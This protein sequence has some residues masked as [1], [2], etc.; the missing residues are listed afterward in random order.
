MKHMTIV[1]LALVVLAG[2]AAA[3]TV[4]VDPDPP[5]AG[6]AVTV[7]YDPTGRPLEGA[8]AVYLHYGYNGWH[9]T[10]D[11]DASM[12]WNAGTSVWEVTVTVPSQAVE[13][14]MAFNDGAGTWD[15]NDG[16]NWTIA[17]T[18]GEP[19]P[20]SVSTSPDPVEASMDVTISY[21]AT[22]GPLASASAV[23]LHHG[24]NNWEIV[25]SDV[26]MTWE[27]DH[28]EATVS[29][30][31]Y[32]VEFDCSFFDDSAEPIWDNNDGFDWRLAVSGGVPRVSV[33][34]DPPVAGM[35]VTITYNPD[36]TVLEGATQVFLH[37]GINDFNPT[38]EDVA[39]N[40]NGPVWEV[41]VTIPIRGCELNFVFN[42]GA[43]TWDNNNG[44]DWNIATEGC[45]PLE[46][47]VDNLY[48]AKLIDPFDPF[49]N[50]L[51]IGVGGNL[52][53]NGSAM[54]IF[55]DTDDMTGQ[56][57]LKAGGAATPPD[58]MPIASQRS[59]TFSCR[60][61]GEGTILPEEADYALFVNY[62]GGEVHFN[63]YFL[64]GTAFDQ[65]LCCDGVS[66]LPVFASQV[67]AGGVEVNLGVESLLPEGLG[68]VGGFDDTNL[69]TNPADVV[70]GL[71]VGIPM[72]RLGDGLGANDNVRIWV[73]LMPN[74]DGV[75]GQFSNHTLPPSDLLA[76]YCAPPA[77]FP[78][79]AD[80]TGYSQFFSTTVTALPTFGGR[81][82]GAIVPDDYSGSPD[83]LQTCEAADPV[84]DGTASVVPDPPLQGEDVTV[85]YVSEGRPLEGAAQ[86][87]LVYG[88]DGWAS[89]PVEVPMIATNGVTGSEWKV[90]IT[91]AADALQLDVQF[92]D[93]LGVDD[94][95]QGQDW[96]FTVGRPSSGE[97]V[98]IDP[99]PALAGENVTITYDP[100]GRVLESAESVW[101]HYG[102]NDWSPV[103]PD[104]QMT[105]TGDCKW[106]VTI[107]VAS[108]AYGPLGLNMAF[109]DGGGTWDNNDGND[110]DFEV[111][112]SLGEPPWAMDG[113]VDACAT[114]I[115]TSEDGSRHLWAGMRDG[116]LY[117]CTERSQAGNDHFIFVAGLPG[118][119]APQPWAKAGTVAQWD[120]YLAQEV[121]NGWVGWFDV[122]DD[123]FRASV[124]QN[125]DLPYL[126]GQIDIGSELGSVPSTVYVAMGPYPTPDGS[127]LIPE[128]QVIPGNGDGNIDF[129]EYVEQSM[130]DIE[131]TGPFADMDF[132]EDCVV[133]P[134]DYVLFE[135]CIDGPDSPPAAGCEV[136]ADV[137]LDLDVDLADWA[138]FQ[139]RITAN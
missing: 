128:M 22:G 13:I 46:S 17:V 75:Q 81:A 134:A 58:L 89:A 49:F 31:S 69:E 84:G 127:P 133:D 33:N 20:D 138:Y 6:M 116:F 95:N 36:D 62:S 80:L 107:P 72:Y 3:D 115:G 45:V 91:A 66:T 67:Y 79:R 124:P 11:P 55:I 121:D 1:A 40:T 54:V 61:V 19:N 30:P 21:D 109:N 93:G 42:D 29:V 7:S 118:D 70:T 111:D 71:E 102:F 100:T 5:V 126:E 68:Y 114:L 47:E 123:T 131:V 112:S 87:N 4:A 94:D 15:N 26:A 51:F 103:M 136:E 14:N 60:A 135:A 56:T 117:M 113:Y 63:E 37:W 34:P 25:R 57:E 41:T 27:T 85:W 78:L 129:A 90:T 16:D 18:G 10:V 43:G 8:A 99:N 132:N 64:S 119:P 97:V 77:M 76:G 98:E 105:G 110:W 35:D 106:E 130:L 125:T 137:D 101:V 83:A 104:E 96:H 59:D 86:V 120:A 28:W 65:R 88:F 24:F 39:M 122:G 74:N 44:N 2:T 108:F 52:E 9:P 92:N 73:A 82:D 139:R 32:A 38:F 48:V 50:L 53:N 12:T 23:F